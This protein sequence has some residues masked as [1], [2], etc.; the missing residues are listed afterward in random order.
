MK[1]LKYLTLVLFILSG[2]KNNTVFS[3]QRTTPLII[4]HTCADVSQV[5]DTE[6]DAIQE[7]FRL[8]YAHTSHGSQLTEGL[9]RLENSNSKYNVAIGYSSLPAQAGALNIFDGQETD[10]YITPD[11]YWESTWGVGL[12]KDVLDH[13][14][15]I[16]LSMWAW[17]CQLDDYNSNQV[18]LY[19]DTMAGLEADYPNITFIYMTGNSQ[20]ESSNRYARNNQIRQ[21][22]INN[23]KVLFDFADLDCWYNGQQNV[24]SGIPCEHPH[25]HGDQAGHTTYESCENKGKAVWYMLAELYDEQFTAIGDG[26][27]SM[28]QQFSLMQNYPNPF[29]PWTNISYTVPEDNEVI[30]TIYN[31]RGEMVK[32]LVHEFQL[33]G[34]YQVRW[35]SCDELGNAVGSGIYFSRI[36][37]GNRKAALKMTLLR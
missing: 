25:Y 31:L 34:K 12:T 16:N 7:N 36:N 15:T 5:S 4:D 14:P 22:C 10:T 33:R 21:F 3:Q 28:A 9:E 17:C 8:H 27:K 26:E 19:L 32:T 20:S 29:N 24:V 13:N 2:L 35:D 1:Y 37:I 23:N 30:L 11:M 18:Q 6:L